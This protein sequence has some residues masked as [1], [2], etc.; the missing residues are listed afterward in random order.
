MQLFD[1]RAYELPSFEEVD[2]SKTKYQ[3]GIFLSAYK[4][5][6]ERVGQPML[7]KLTTEYALNN[8]GTTSVRLDEDLIIH[9]SY[10]SE[11]LKLDE[12]FTL[13]Y[14]SIVHP[15]R[16]EVTDRRR[17]IFMLRYVY[18][19]PVT[20]VSERI[21][22]Q[23]NIIIEDSKKTMIQFSRSTSLLVLKK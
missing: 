11:F 16:P 7:P 20:R 4:I 15:Y 8:L 13:G 12:M 3:V 10:R 2:W 9:E 17:K 19:L 6:R 21:H 23:K 18:G 5:A 14:S 1:L 22:Y